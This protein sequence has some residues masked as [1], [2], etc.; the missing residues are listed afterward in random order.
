MQ[1]DYNTNEDLALRIRYLPALAFVPP[2]DVHD[3]FDSVVEQ[4]PMPAAQ[5]LILYFE[6]TYIGRRLPGGFYQEP[7]FPIEMWN[8]HH[9]V[10][11]GIPR[12][13]NA[14]EAW[15]RSYNATIGC[16]HPNIW[17]FINA[18][19]QEQGLVEVRQAKFIAGE[20]PTKRR[21]D[22]ANEEGLKGLIFGYFHRLPLE[23]LRGVAHR[24]GL[25]DA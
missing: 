10:P 15:H 16:C 20:K 25:N 1:G 24:I 17:R 7:I 3:Y 5:G 22:K 8:H 6:R 11:Q 2:L 18:L 23:F 9:E 19:K 14:V 21:K 13:T 4:L 12:T